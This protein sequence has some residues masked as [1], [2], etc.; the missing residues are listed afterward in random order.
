MKYP[1]GSIITGKVRG[2]KEYG[3]FLEIEKGIDGLVHVVICLGPSAIRTQVICMHMVIPFR[4]KSRT[5]MFNVR[6]CL[7]ASKT[8]MK[9]HG[10]VYRAVTSSVKWSKVKWHL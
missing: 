6:D 8:S 3:I 1:V 10:L 5:S 2:I 4:R 9:T 7:S